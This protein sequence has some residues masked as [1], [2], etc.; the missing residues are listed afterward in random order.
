MLNGVQAHTL[1]SQNRV[2]LC[3]MKYDS[4]DNSE[5]YV[6]RINDDESWEEKCITNWIYKFDF[7]GYGSIIFE[8]EIEDMRNLGDG[9][10]G[11]SYYHSMYGNGEIILDKTTLEPIELREY[12]PTYPTELDSVTTQGTY[13]RPIEVKINQVGNYILRWETMEENNDNEPTS[14]LSDD[15]MLE[16]IELESNDTISS[17]EKPISSNATES[18]LQVIQNQST[19]AI[20]GLN[21]GN[22]VTIINVNGQVLDKFVATKTEYY[23]PAPKSG[24]YMVNA[25]KETRKIIIK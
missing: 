25:G 10:L 14:S 18:S 11:V 2:V 5:L 6:Y 15:Y 20:S 12:A 23:L 1:D 16:F 7:S 9:T 22:V 24:F 19:V 4:L 17:I 3:N 21:I 8:I 13:E